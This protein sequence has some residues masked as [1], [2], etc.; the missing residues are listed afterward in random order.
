MAMQIS[1]ELR[2]FLKAF[3][4]AKVILQVKL[5]SDSGS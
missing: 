5:K 4:L 2:T 3:A 1:L